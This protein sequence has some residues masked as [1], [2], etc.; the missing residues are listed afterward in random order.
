MLAALEITMHPGSALLHAESV[1]AVPFVVGVG[2]SGTTL[3]RLM[4]D[5]HPALAI[6]PETHFL[7]A[8]LAAPPTDGRAF[9]TALTSAHTWP[10]FHLDA[11]A[12][13]AQ[14]LALEP[15]RLDEAVRLFYAAYARRF[16]KHRWGDKSPPYIEC[17]AD[18][19]RLLPEAKFIHI[20]RDGRDVALSYRDKWFGPGQDIGDAARFWRRRILAA[21]GAGLPASHYLE[22]RYEDLLRQPEVVLQRIC[23]FIDLPFDPA[24]LEYHRG[25]SA[26]LGEVGDWKDAAGRLMAPREKLLAI[27]DRT[28][29][30]L[31]L[32]QIGKW[33][34]GLSAVEQAT[35]LEINGDLLRELEYETMPPKKN[36]AQL[37]LWTEGTTVATV[38]FV[39]GMHRSGTSAITRLLNCLGLD[40]GTHLL[41]PRQDNPEGFFEDAGVVDINRRLLN[42]WSSTWYLPVD[43]AQWEAPPE[44]LVNEA[45]ELLAGRLA[46]RRNWLVKD[47]RLCLLLPFWLARL[48]EL[49]P[50]A[51][52]A[53]FVW[54]LRHP[55]NV[56]AS[57]A[58]RDGFSLDHGRQL[59]LAHN[60]AILRHLQGRPVWLLDYDRL[61]AQP[62]DS[63]LALSAGLGLTAERPALEAACNDALRPDL[64]HNQIQ[65]APAH[66]LYQGLGGRPAQAL[67]TNE[68]ARLWE[69]WRNELPDLQGAWRWAAGLDDT[70]RRQVEQLA[71]S[72]SRESLLRLGNE[73]LHRD[74]AA[75]RA[76]IEDL[77]S[78]RAALSAEL[79]NQVEALVQMTHERDRLQGTLEAREQE[80][81]RREAELQDTIAGILASTSWKVTEPLRRTSAFLRG[82]GKAGAADSE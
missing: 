52:E 11:A 69:T 70:V 57:L 12:L 58:T 19:H 63:A 41:P 81:A 18:L 60:L 61:L 53:R 67:A 45:R 14:V 78:Q 9:M 8:L 74:V 49:G 28:R 17:L 50:H 29:E 24:M 21:R 72:Q 46:E 33:R 65:D 4:L 47:P 79:A 64:R 68:L 76:D 35:F 25:A 27:H 23:R 3:L 66:P 82:L 44:A 13:E 31:D 48:A 2:R 7:M 51:P 36:Q 38:T 32:S 30:P 20:I 15:F 56:A 42:H 55:D 59:W 16:G 62:V 71:E 39:L 80:H 26:R 73:N 40:V 43:P 10:D 34:E 22:V 75:L 77:R 5:A 37:G 6:P 54:M 1:P